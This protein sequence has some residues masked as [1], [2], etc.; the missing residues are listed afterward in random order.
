MLSYT[1]FILHLY[2]LLYQGSTL[3][4]SIYLLRRLA[5]RV[6]I[7]CSHRRLQLFKIHLDA[8]TVL[9]LAIIWMIWGILR[10]LRII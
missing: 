2:S 4:P 7:E 3:K 8:R 1:Q 9:V 10:M 6:S 5:L